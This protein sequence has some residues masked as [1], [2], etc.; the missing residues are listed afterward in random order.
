MRLHYK[1]LGFL[2]G[3]QDHSTQLVG[4]PSASVSELHGCRTT[5]GYNPTEL[6]LRGWSAG[7]FSLPV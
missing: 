5:E 6:I 7:L 3:L 4:A 2:S 1:T